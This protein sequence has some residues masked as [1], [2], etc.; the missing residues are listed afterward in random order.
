VGNLQLPE[1]VRWYDDSFSAPEL[2][3]YQE[4]VACSVQV[5]RSMELSNAVLLAIA[6]HHEHADGSGFPQRLRLE[7]MSML[8]RILSLVNRYDSLCNPARQGAAM[9][10][11]EALSLIYAQLKCRYDPTV[12]SAFIRMMGVYPPGSVVQLIDDRHA[13]VVSVNSARPLKPRVLVHEPGVPKH[14]ALVLDLESTPQL[15]IRRS[16]RPGNLPGSAMDYLAP[17]Q[18]IYYFYEQANDAS[19]AQRQAQRA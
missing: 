15:G 3:L 2:K 14:E 9:T 11:H 18:R 16:L 7:S 17:R 6:Q 4:H 13:I 5:G 19:D 1:R 10:P 12:L 8:A